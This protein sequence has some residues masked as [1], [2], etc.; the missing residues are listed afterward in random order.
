MRYKPR[1]TR[2]ETEVVRTVPKAEDFGSGCMYKSVPTAL[3][4]ATR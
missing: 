3:D 4:S 2:A 1:E